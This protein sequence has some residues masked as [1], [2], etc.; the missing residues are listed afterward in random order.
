MDLD[1]FV[2]VGIA[3]PTLRFLDVFLLHCLLADSPPDTPQEIAALG[4]NQHRTAARG[5]ESGL[6]LERGSGEV[7]LADWGAQLLAE[8]ATIAAALDGEH[9]GTRYSEALNAASAT[10]REPDGL[11]SARVLAT[12]VKDFDSSYVRFTRAQ[13]EQTRNALLARPFPSALRERFEALAKES[14]AAQQAIEALDSL[15]FEIYR[16][17]YLASERLRVSPRMRGGG[18]TRRKL[19]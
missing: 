8:C 4:R 19:G 7:T 2:P 13:S 12:M 17:Q 15:P 5:R 3:A 6:L 1:P 11:S 9:G 18:A 16:Q 10:L 14:N